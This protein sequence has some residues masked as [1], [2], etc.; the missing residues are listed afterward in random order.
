MISIEKIIGAHEGMEA[1]KE[2]ESIRVE[3]EEYPL[4]V[5]EFLGPGPTAR[6]AMGVSQ[7]IKQANGRWLCAREMQFEITVDNEWF[8]FA[9][10]S[11]TTGEHKEVYEPV[12]QRFGFLD[13]N[14][15]SLIDTRTTLP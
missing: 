1:L 2:F 12:L 4:L 3:H 10:S 13:L 5:I 11:E 7:F 14:R 8:P 6:P 9:L 15:I